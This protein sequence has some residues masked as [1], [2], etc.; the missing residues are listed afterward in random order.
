MA[1][2]SKKRRTHYKSRNGCQQCK[3]RHV[4]CDEQRP[5]CLQCSM[6]DRS[7]LYVRV[8]SNA[9][10]V[11]SPAT[12]TGQS[13]TS[14]LAAHSEVCHAAS[15]P[16]PVLREVPEQIFDLNHLVLFHHVQSGLMRPPNWHFI[17]DKENAQKLLHMVVR[18]ALS[19]P[20]LMDAVLGF[21]ALH[22]G[23]LAPDFTTQRRYRLQAIQL[24]TRALAL[25]NTACPEITDQ[26]CTTLLLYSSFI[27][28]HM[29]HETVT[30]QMNPRELLDK[31]I[32]FLGLHHGV[33][34]I[35]SCAWHIIRSSELSS[36]LD[37]IEGTDGL[38]TPSERICDELHC[39]LAATKDRLGSS[40]FQA[41]HDAVRFL[42]WIFHRR[43]VLPVPISQHIVL[44]WPVHIPIAYLQ[45]LRE[46]QPEAL[47]I[48]AYWAV[49]LHYERDCWVFGHGGRFLIE[50]ISDYLGAYWDKWLALPRE[51]INADSI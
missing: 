44:A 28:M 51:I 12:V 20:Y 13:P 1:P 9:G 29:L 49:L 11:S 30:S 7:C 40:S 18:S 36:I 24:Q 14:Y 48:M 33:K 2:P 27:G 23:T 10:Q 34:V 42:Q 37:L 35:T 45:M 17:A 50:A 38:E 46:R 47:V 3:Q 5:A 32:L 8:R 16:G 39:F 6:T 43:R 22:L 26:N 19:T 15:S 25:Y 21:A 4:K 31:F 41:C